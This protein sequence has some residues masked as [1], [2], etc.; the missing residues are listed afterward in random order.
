MRGRGLLAADVAWRRL[1]WAAFAGGC[2]G[3]SAGQ[4]E[5]DDAERGDRAAMA[6][7]ERLTFP[8]ASAFRATHVNSLY[9]E[10]CVCNTMIAVSGL[11]ISC[12]TPGRA[13]PGLQGVRT[14]GAA[15]VCFAHRDVAKQTTTNLDV[16]TSIA[17]AE[18]STRLQ[19]PFSCVRSMSCSPRAP[20]RR[21][22][23][24]RTPSSRPREHWTKPLCACL[25]P[26]SAGQPSGERVGRP[27]RA[28]HRV[29]NLGRARST[30][31]TDAPRRPS[32]LCP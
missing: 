1:Q 8:R 31:G 4:A 5:C 23:P 24:R 15:P 27:A 9:R 16:S 28:R 12:A 2:R 30:P 14:G 29:R 17:E 25:S 6:S 22:A 10:K 18:V 21:R 3:R 7:P 13:T 19:L 32:L 20:P 26:Q 11:L